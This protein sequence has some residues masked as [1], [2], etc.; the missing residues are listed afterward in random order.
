MAHGVHPAVKEVE[1]T[2]RNPVV[3][4]PAAHTER[5]QLA[6]GDDA[7]LPLRPR[8]DILSKTSRPI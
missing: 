3:D 7:V 8:G 1:P 2:G 4:G 6:P 5:E